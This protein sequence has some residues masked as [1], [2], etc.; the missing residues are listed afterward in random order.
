MLQGLLSP[1]N[2]PVVSLR[3]IR[4]SRSRVLLWWYLTRSN[5]LKSIAYI[6][7]FLREEKNLFSEKK[8]YRNWKI[9]DNV[10]HRLSIEFKKRR[11][12]C[13]RKKELQFN[14]PREKKKGKKIGRLFEGRKFLLSNESFSFVSVTKERKKKRLGERLVND[15]HNCGLLSQ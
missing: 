11:A 14:S 3:L 15:G 12:P 7:I 4:S 9:V 2:E 10:V 13:R 1:P 8:N 5:I 6:Y